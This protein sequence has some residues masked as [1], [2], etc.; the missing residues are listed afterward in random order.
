MARI[1]VAEDDRFTR[2]IVQRALETAG[3]QVT[4]TEDGGEALASFYS[5]PS[6]DLVITDVEMPNVSGLE[7]AE[8]LLAKNA[9][10][11]I[12]IMSGLAGELARAEALVCDNVRLI[13]KPVTLEKIRSEAIALLR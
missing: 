13:T 8:R 1:L 9:A 10:Q 2:E 12:L 6:F 4:T 3:H 11:P 5:G 7:L